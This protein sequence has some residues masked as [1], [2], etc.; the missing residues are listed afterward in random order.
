[1]RKYLYALLLVI[2]QPTFA[3]DVQAPQAYMVDVNTG[4]ILLEKNADQKM[5]P[6][7]MSKIMTAHL[8]F[9]R[10]KSGDVKLEDMLHVSKEAW[11]MGGSKMFVQVNS[12][13]SVGDLLQGV[14][15]QSGNDA[16]IVLA[17]GL[18]G[19][20]AAF[21]E[22]MTRKA[23]EMGAKN[24]TFVNTTGWPDEGHVSTAR[25]LAIMADRTI[26]DFPQEYE[27]YYSM[28]EFT[29]NNI[30]QGNRNTLLYKNM[31]ADGMK[32]GHT[33]AGGYGIVATA[34]Q[35]DRRIILVI[36]GLP[37]SKARDQEATALLNWGFSYFKNYKIFGKG[38]VVETAD[39]WGGEEKSIDLV[40]GQDIIFTLPRSQRKDLQVKVRYDSP[41]AAPL[42]AGDKVGTLE[43]TIPEKG[44]QVIPL[45]AAKDLDKA[46]FFQRINN[47]IHYLLWGKHSS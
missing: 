46:S 25:D 42:K 4:A 1:M 30:K 43:I 13:V 5:A 32:T 22:E 10:L 47:S 15:V 17:E 41:L 26:R 6:S 40:S 8:V 2:S 16:C 28:K 3:I 39:V 29:Y 23:N 14:I 37:S 36:N 20:E 9:E 21:A 19:T 11:Q 35:G 18:G 27:K 31:G 34:K 33:E 45:L 7:S 12:Q 38:D 44:V 24:T